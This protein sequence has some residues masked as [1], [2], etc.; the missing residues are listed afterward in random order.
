M[1]HGVYRGSGT[2]PRASGA[3]RRRRTMVSWPGAC[4]VA[5]HRWLF[6]APRANSATM[7][8]IRMAG[9]PGF[10]YYITAAFNARPFGM[11]VAPN[12][13]GLAAVG[14]LGVSIPGSGC[15]APASSSGYLLY[16]RDQRALPAP[17]RRQQQSGATSDWD[18]RITRRLRPLGERDRRRYQALA[19]RCRSILDLQMSTGD[20]A[21]AG[22][23]SST[24]A[25]AGCRGCTCGCCRAPHDRAGARRGRRDALGR[26]DAVARGLE[27]R[28]EGEPL[29]DE[30]APQPRGPDRDPQAAHRPP[31]RGRHAAD[32]H[33]RRARR[34]SSS[35]SS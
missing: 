30:A 12:W 10:F 31:R 15:S 5:I 23:E 21:P 26:P 33:R 4:A 17:D 29:N 34:A 19:D 25:S 1:M 22:L 3:G 8:R 7:A 6:D 11:S 2:L 35:R 28:L 13:V 9:K 16:A 24:R 20:A 32:V 14:L 27:R 18:A